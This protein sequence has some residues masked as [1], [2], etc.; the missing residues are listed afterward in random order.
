MSYQLFEELQADVDEYLRNDS[1]RRGGTA[2]RMARPELG[3]VTAS[4]ENH[5]CRVPQAWLRRLL[6]GM[7]VS[8]LRMLV[9][10]FAVLVS[11]SRVLLRVFVFAVSVV[12]GSLEMM[13]GGGVMASRCQV[14]ML[15]RCVFLVG[16]ETTS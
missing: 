14:M 8:V 5:A 9:A 2:A 4:K 16:H 10:V 12:M 6:V 13:M 7:V 1:T 15:H 3:Q 11:G